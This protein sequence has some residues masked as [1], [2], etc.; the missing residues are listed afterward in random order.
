MDMQKNK[1]HLY[2]YRHNAYKNIEA[3]AKQL[4]KEKIEIKRGATHFGGVL[5]WAYYKGFEIRITDYSYDDRIR[6][7][8]FDGDLKRLKRDFK[9]MFKSIDNLQIKR[10]KDLIKKY[11]ELIK[12]R[13]LEVNS[14]AFLLKKQEYLDMHIYNINYVH[15]EKH[16]NDLISAY[17]R[18]VFTH[19]ETFR[20]PKSKDRARYISK[21]NKGL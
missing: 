16:L 18:G 14:K 7:V 2:N 17:K 11:K 15:I 5:C 1:E 6:T 13:E 8:Y 9:Q 20:Y 4:T 19:W 21:I 3:I 10:K 12:K